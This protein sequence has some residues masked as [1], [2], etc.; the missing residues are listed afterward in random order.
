VLLEIKKVRWKSRRAKALNKN[1]PVYLLSSCLSTLP[2]Q[3]S[4]QPAIQTGD[5]PSGKDHHPA[6]LSQSQHKLLNMSVHQVVDE[7]FSQNVVGILVPRVAAGCCNDMPSAGVLQEL[8][9]GDTTDEELCIQAGIP[10][11]YCACPYPTSFNTGDNG[12]MSACDT[13]NACWGI[14]NCCSGYEIF[15]RGQPDEVTCPAYNVP[16]GI[17]DDCGHCGL[18]HLEGGGCCVQPAPDSLGWVGISTFFNDA[19]CWPNST[20]PWL[21]YCVPSA[22]PPPCPP[23]S[24]SSSS[25]GMGQRG[26]D[27]TPASFFP[28]DFRYRDLCLQGKILDISKFDP[29]SGELV[30]LN[31]IVSDSAAD[32]SPDSSSADSPYSENYTGT[33]AG[34]RPTQNACMPMKD[35]ASVPLSDTLPDSPG[36]AFGYYINVDDEQTYDPRRVL[37]EVKNKYNQANYPN[38]N[39]FFIG[40]NV[41]CPN[42]K[43]AMQNGVLPESLPDSLGDSLPDSVPPRSQL[44]QVWAFERMNAKNCYDL[45]IKKHDLDMIGFHDVST[46]MERPGNSTT[47]DPLSQVDPLQSILNSCQPFINGKDAAGLEFYPAGSRP[48]EKK[49]GYAGVLEY[50]FRPDMDEAEYILSNYMQ[51]EK[52]YPAVNFVRNV[53]LPCV[54]IKDPATLPIYPVPLPSVPAPAGCPPP[55]PPCGPYTHPIP[56]TLKYVSPNYL[57]EP[58]L[59]YYCPNIEKITE[60][61]HPFSPRMD[62]THADAQPNNVST[63]ADS[64]TFDS[65]PGSL[66][67]WSQRG[68]LTDRDYTYKTSVQWQN[69]NKVGRCYSEDRQF[70]YTDWNAGGPYDCGSR[71][72]ADMEL[73]PVVQCAIVPVDILSFRLA[74]F[75]NCMMQRIDYNIDIFLL[76]WWSEQFASTAPYI[77]TSDWDINNPA[78]RGP[79]S[80]QT[81]TQPQLPLVASHPSNY[82]VYGEGGVFQPGRPD[83]N[84]PVLNDPNSPNNGR[85]NP[86]CKTRFFESDDVAH[87]PVNMSIQ[88]CCHIITKDVVPAN[89][90]KIRTCEGLRQT[91]LADME[92]WVESPAAGSTST[93]SS[94]SSSSGGDTN[95]FDG[96]SDDFGDSVAESRADSIA[97]CPVPPP[98]Q[99]T[100]GIY[101]L[102]DD[103][104]LVDYN[105]ATNEQIMDGD[106]YKAALWYDEYLNSLGWQTD[107]TDGGCNNTEPPEYTFRN[108][109]ES[110]YDDLNT[111]ILVGYHMPYMRWY[112]SAVSAGQQSHGGSFTNTLGGFDT[113][114]GVGRE[115]RSKEDSYDVNV[116]IN[117]FKGPI[118]DGI[119]YAIGNPEQS[120][121]GR[122]GGWLELK[123]HEMYTIRRSNLF[124][125]GRYEK[126]FKPGSADEFAYRRAGGG[127]LNTQGLEYPWPL[128]WRGYGSDTHGQGFPYFGGAGFIETGLDKALPGDIISYQLN[129]VTQIA[130]VSNV[131]RENGSVLDISILTWDQGKFPDP[132]GASSMWAMGV[133]RQIYKYA[134]PQGDIG[135]STNY[136]NKTLRTLTNPGGGG[137]ACTNQEANPGMTSAQCIASNCQPSCADPSYIHCVLPD[138]N[139]WANAIVMHPAASASMRPGGDFC[140]VIA[141][142]PISNSPKV[143]G[144]NSSSDTPFIQTN[145]FSWM[146]NMGFDPPLELRPLQPVFD[147]NDAAGTAWRTQYGPPPQEGVEGGY[148]GAGVLFKPNLCGPAWTTMDQTTKQLLELGCEA[149][150]CPI[151]YKFYPPPNIS[152]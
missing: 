148:R 64:P 22:P 128:G 29:V 30:N 114:I 61:S 120:Q 85:F 110:Y 38:E 109:F 69:P 19:A 63:I 130:Y 139:A 145:Y 16:G 54:G 44:Q 142:Q 55:P 10:A 2:N 131:N 95:D 17:C 11:G 134:V 26:Q 123:G 3:T 13:Q 59:N 65:P 15:A 75:N 126:L 116:L 62:V 8:R 101:N 46:T 72:C 112:D 80:G 93:S 125:M 121:M 105:P 42:L 150:A 106:S 5:A 27:L 41:G 35:T 43:L 108:W 143:T 50:P 67:F 60:P 146:V 25:S 118:T 73:D 1:W 129:G 40:G 9:E 81:N 36:M 152:R 49:S 37:N 137:G 12:N 103:Y 45:Y 84:P 104:F 66:G 91:R 82:A 77:D 21:A 79:F 102:I 70:L 144:V 31:E 92:L 136:C 124:C 147:P 28:Q 133:Q 78:Y 98:Q 88:Q 99:H 24:S 127:Y 107:G 149:N 20:I 4:A 48:N 100:P 6:Q 74:S 68:T 151:Q 56:M 53:G 89:F 76:W 94:T 122:I 33:V 7:F 96:D 135:G 87:C 23:P 113:L 132:T 90:L 34:V 57:P 86:P 52:T 18:D 141:P 138:P 97:V 39:N 51:L 117:G 58:P 115:E 111:G 83:Q 140:S 71:Y 32:A 47:A 119:A 14:M